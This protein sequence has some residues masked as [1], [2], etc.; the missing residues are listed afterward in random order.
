MSISPTPFPTHALLANHA[1]VWHVVRCDAFSRTYV[2]LK[3]AS[4]VKGAFYNSN[5]CSGTLWGQ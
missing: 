1:S 5:R 4:L 3:T 2:S